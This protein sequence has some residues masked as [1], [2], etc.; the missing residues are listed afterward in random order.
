MNKPV[1]SYIYAIHSNRCE[2]L[3]RIADTLLGCLKHFLGVI[4]IVKSKI[5][6]YHDTECLFLGLK[7]CDFGKSRYIFKNDL[8]QI[9]DSVIGNGIRAE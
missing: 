6:T 4:T 7:G 3:Y 5:E 9:K 8:D 1:G 2:F